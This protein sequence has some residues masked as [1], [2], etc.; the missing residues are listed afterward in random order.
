MAFLTLKQLESLFWKNT[1]KILGIDETVPGNADLVRKAWQPRGAPAWGITK[2]VAFIRIGE[3]EDPFS[4]LRD[5]ILNPHTEDEAKRDN[6]Y[7]RVIQ[8]H[9]VF[10]GPN[11][12]DRASRLRNLIFFDAYR[13]D[14]TLNKI[15]LIPEVDTPRR[16]PELW[17]GQWWERTDVTASFNNLVTIQD[18][19]PYFKS[20]E[21]TVNTPEKVQDASVNSDTKI[22]IDK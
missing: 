14:L 11:S 10:Y 6:G 16:V 12:Y 13:E 8:V 7:T 22:I 5:A 1:M 20:A 9:W 21:I 18:L 17:E 15:F 2:D 3:K 19:I 4:I